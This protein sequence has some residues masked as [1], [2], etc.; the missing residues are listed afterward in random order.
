MRDVTTLALVA[1]LLAAALVYNIMLTPETHLPLAFGVPILVAAHRWPPRPVV[2]TVGAAFVLDILVGYVHGFPPTTFVFGIISLALVGYL[3]VLFAARRQEAEALAAE[4]QQRAAELSAVL[5]AL[6]D[7]YFRLDADGTVL[8]YRAGTTTDVY[9]PPEAY[10]GRRI[11]EALP[12]AVGRL[13]DDAIRAVRERGEQVAIEY[14][15]PVREA[16]RFFEARLLPLRQRHVV[17]VVRDVTERRRADSALRESERKYR[18]L[19]DHIPQKV[20]YKNRDGVYLAVNPSYANDFGLS[21]QEMVGKSDRDLFPP[22]L[23]EKYAADDR[24]IMAT[25][26]AEEF[27][28]TYFLAG[29]ERIV[30]TLKVPVRANGD[31]VTGVLGIFWDI[32]ERKR[33]EESARTAAANY[34]AIF[35]AANDAIF[36]HDP[37]TGAILDVNQKMCEMYA[38]T[39]EEARRLTVADL[40]AAEP[41]YTQEEAMQ[42]IRKA[43][44][45]EPQLFEWLARARDGREFWV[46]VNLKSAVIG[47]QQRLLAIVRDITER[48]RTEA[49]REEYVSLVSHDLRQPLT[50]V[51]GMAEW[52]QRRLAEKALDRE[53]ST[54]WRIVQSARRM[55]SMISDL[56]ESAR[57]EAGR[58]ELH[59]EPTDVARLLRDIAARVGTSEDRKRIRV[60]PIGQVPAV[61]AD[62]EKLERVVVNL[63]TNALKFSPPASPVVVSVERVQNEVVVSVRD[64]GVGIPAGDLPHLFQRYYRAMTGKKK[65]GLG[66]G[67]YIARLIVE[68]HGGRIW[69]ESEVGKGSTF[70]F[71][72]PAM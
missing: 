57:L 46:E 58:L 24:R 33:A 27:D 70:F 3:A 60:E 34:R 64:Q 44:E 35:D 11:Q 21:P 29:E 66:L 61:L 28:E 14:S 2:V 68:A 69:A 45:G 63:V 26:N 48:K 36:V 67:L 12:P 39:P 20:F 41:P 32:T 9:L 37:Q 18:T 59:K 71:A 42:L 13:F 30:H 38:C 10:L 72:L 53:A 1:A 56:A 43:A 4:A 19:L 50:V 17:V 6:P 22:A 8:D 5:S 62:P 31:A 7:L 55:G 49:F 15:L 47:G 16:E 52:L 51:A 25:G 23:A 40:S 54:A 65:E